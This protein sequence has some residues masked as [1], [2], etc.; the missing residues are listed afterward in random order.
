[1]TPKQVLR[2]PT[3]TVIMSFYYQDP[4]D[5]IFEEK[6][7][8]HVPTEVLKSR[9]PKFEDL[10][11]S[12]VT[13]MVYTNLQFNLKRIFESVY[14]TPIDFTRSKK[15][16]Y[17]NKKDLKPGYGSIISVNWG[18][19]IRG[20]NMRKSKLRWC[21]YTCQKKVILEDGT[22]TDEKINTVVEEIVEDEYIEGLL[23]IKFYC[24]ECRK[25]YT[26]KQLDQI[27]NFLNQVTLSLCIG[28][29]IVNIMIFHDSIKIA[30]CKETS[31]AVETIQ[32]LW[33]D[34]ISQIP[35]SY[36]ISRKEDH[37]EFLFWTVMKNLSFEIGFPLDRDKTKKLFESK[38][39]NITACFENTSQTSVNLKFP[40]KKPK[41]HIYWTLNYEIGKSKPGLSDGTIWTKNHSN[42]YKKKKK[43]KGKNTTFIVF[44]SSEIILSGRYPTTMKELYYN[45]VDIVFENRNEIE[46]VFRKCPDDFNNLFTQMSNKVREWRESESSSYEDY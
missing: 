38:I 14:V 41:D 27:T 28:E 36:Y 40:T 35:S 29:K 18:P 22:E 39:K 25:Y 26:H 19:M 12:T 6:E 15:K 42:P 9:I 21:A 3:L 7:V 33:E 2:Q 8:E 17:I 37:I 4:A 13:E 10:K 45:F 43:K 34:Y 30:G 46:E 11:V 24:T 44:S 32:L 31:D 20:L 23:H 1:M 5:C 16:R